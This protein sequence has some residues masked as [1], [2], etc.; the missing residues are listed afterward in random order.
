[1]KRYVRIG[2]ALLAAVV[3]SWYCFPSVYGA[4]H[5][6]VCTDPGSITS[7]PALRISA[8]DSQFVRSGNDERLSDYRETEQ[9]VRLFGLIPLRTF[10]EP[11]NRRTVRIGGE[12]VGVILHTLG[13][14]IVGLGALDTDDGNRSPAADA[15]LL[16]GDMILSVNGTPVTD[17][18]SF[19]RLCTSSGGTCTLSCLRNQE[20]F[21]VTLQPERD[22]D[23]ALKIGAWVRDSTSGIGT[24]SF[25][26]A[27]RGAYAALGHGVT[28]VDTQK[29]LSPATGFLT[30]AKI[31]SVR[32]GSAQEAGELIG[33]FSVL[34]SDR[35]ATIETNTEFGISGKLTKRPEQTVPEVAIAPAD[36]AHLG[37]AE[38]YATVDGETARSYAVRIIRVD[39]QS[40]PSIQGMMIEIIDPELLS[41]TGGI[42]QGMSG[43]P[44]IQDG[45]L[46][47]V[48]THVFV[49]HPTRG[50]CLYAAWMAQKLLP[51]T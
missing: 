31:T 15:G 30:E 13:V 21:T 11:S 2:T 40:A 8:S 12:A 27:Q 29:L 7:A 50:Y 33:T 14:Q 10:Y 5:V 34:E 37:N 26:D 18:A 4:L 48:V 19:M 43:S 45:K 49:S 24:L 38:I 36:A 47:G 44:L 6:P 35:I 39:V 42:V 23:G 22:R 16:P 28:D 17:T 46:I 51:S 3:L 32:T 41:K 20:P 25:Y 1:M 9:T